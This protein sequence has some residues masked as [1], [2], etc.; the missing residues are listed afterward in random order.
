MKDLCSKKKKNSKRESKE[1]IKKIKTRRGEEEILKKN[2][3]R[4]MKTNM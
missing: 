3:A 1:M 4:N 2:L